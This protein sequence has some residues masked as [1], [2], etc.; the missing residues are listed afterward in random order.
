VVRGQCHQTVDAP[1]PIIVSF[2]LDELLSSPENKALVWQ[3]LLLA[4]QLLNA[5]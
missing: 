4:K 5:N 1:I 2:S 3:D